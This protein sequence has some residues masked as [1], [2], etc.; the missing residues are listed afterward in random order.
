MF[1]VIKV[2]PE[3]T[4]HEF[5]RLLDSIFTNLGVA[6]NAFSAY[7]IATEMWMGQLSFN[8]FARTV[9]TAHFRRAPPTAWETQGNP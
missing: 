5:K 2:N 7:A 6:S 4:Y 1:H 9:L 3:L 8:R